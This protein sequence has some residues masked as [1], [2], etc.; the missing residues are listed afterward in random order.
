M[1]GWRRGALLGGMEIFGFLL[2]IF[3]AFVLY[4][5]LTPAFEALGISRNFAKA[6]AFLA[7][8]MTAS[9]I[10]SL[11]IRRIYRRIPLI[12]QCSTANKVLGVIPAAIRGLILISLLAMLFVV[13]PGYEEM[14]KSILASTLGRPLVEK[15]SVVEQQSQEIFGGALRD[16]LTFLTI[17]PE[18]TSKER[19]DLRFRV[20]DVQVDVL[21]E[22]E[23]IVLLNRERAVHGLP[24]LVMDPRLRAV[25][26]QH[27]RD[28]FAR[29]YFA[30]VSPEGV[31][32]FQRMHRAEIDYLT[33]G[34][35]L[36]L[37][38]TVEIAHNGLMRS[39]G[40]KENILHS[41][42]HKIGIG[43]MRSR[44][45]GRMFTQEFTN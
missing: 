10:S 12:I 23:M 45:H 3:F 36:A 20:K 9:I 27:S 26:R 31:T 30:H 38:P 28:M 19:V 44:F 6:G 33:A 41:E 18:L 5:K 21:A 16:T 13:A 42:F 35:N 29:G 2:S 43:V 24:R 17:E 22:E 8:W 34:E 40:H 11:I 25:A 14:S 4:P 1:I 7:F 32:P 15:V 37:A 39:P